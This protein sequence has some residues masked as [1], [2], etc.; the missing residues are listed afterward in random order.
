MKV[1]GYLIH[2]FG[3]ISSMPG[4]VCVNGGF[5]VP[6][7]VL[8]WR[9]WSCQPCRGADLQGLAWLAWPSR[10]VEGRERRCQAGT[11]SQKPCGTRAWEAEWEACGPAGAAAQIPDLLPRPLSVLG[12]AK[13]P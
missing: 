9:D 12:A 10:G 4:E 5:V 7:L 8:P 6:G 1:F 13:N 2:L 3:S 11:G